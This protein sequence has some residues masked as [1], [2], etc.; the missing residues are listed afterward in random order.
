MTIAKYCKDKKFT[1]EEFNNYKNNVYQVA[2]AIRSTLK[3]NGGVYK[4]CEPLFY[5]WDEDI[6]HFVIQ[7]LK[8]L[9]VEF[10]NDNKY[11]RV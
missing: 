1:K 2:K 4:E 10:I 8:D 11:Y 3:Y 5:M 7:E 6:K 9:G